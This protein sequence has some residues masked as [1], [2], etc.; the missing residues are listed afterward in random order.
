MSERS[1]RAPAEFPVHLDRAAGAPLP[2]QLA[3][4]LREVIDAAGLRPGEEVPATRRLASRLGVARGVV[5]SAYEQLI[6]EGYLRAERGRG[7][8]VNPDL[9]PA[10]AAGRSAA[11]APGGVPV[12]PGD[13]PGAARE[14]ERPSPDPHDPTGPAGPE[15]EGAVARPPLAPGA[16]L[17]DAAEHPAWRAAWRRAAARA[18][19]RPPA[20]GDPRLRAEL[21]EHLRLVRGTARPA[22]DVLVTAGTREGLGLLLTALGTTRGNGLV[23]GVEDPGYPSLRGVAARHGARIVSLPV[24]AD[25]LRTDDLPAGVLDLVIVT[26]S[27]QYPVGGSLPLPRRRELLDWAW[28]T[29]VVVVEDDYDSELRHV[30]SPLPTLAAL[31]DPFAGS[32]VTLGTFSSTVTPALSAGFLLAPEQLRSLLEPVRSD[33]GSPVSAV[34]QLALA[35]YL[36]SGELRRNIAR[37]RRRHA[38]RRDLISECF[39][40]VAGARVR[41]MSGGLHAVVELAGAASTAQDREAQAVARAAEPVPGFPNGLGVA[42]LGAYWQHHR[43]D[44]SAGL[45]L[46]MGGPDDAE[47]GAAIARLRAILVE[48]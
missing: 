13:P 47:F 12:R 8:V 35:D 45:V 42:A 9:A 43:S 37:V 6:A 14:R 15:P 27:H 46:G 20:L 26:P 48:G 30:G 29:G 40:G 41:P 38:A 36:A 39:A 25:G 19:H 31:D 22:R 23:V 3:A 32:V 24:D 11:S 7:T 4:A 10:T 28:R 17:T 21:A 2:V 33:L 44:R 18:D 16:P 1:F 34:V 5:V